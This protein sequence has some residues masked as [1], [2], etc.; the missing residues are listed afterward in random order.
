MRGLPLIAL[1][2]AA[3]LP[4]LAA[5]RIPLRPPLKGPLRLA[6]D[7]GE[8]RPHRLLPGIV[9]RT[10]GGKS[11]EPVSAAADGYVSRIVMRHDGYG[12][13]LYLRHPDGRSTVYAHLDRFSADLEA[14][15][16]RIRQAREA[17]EI[18]LVLDATL[19]PVKAGQRIGWTGSSGDVDGPSLHFEVREKGGL[20]ASDPFAA[21][22]RLADRT[23]PEITGLRIHALDDKLLPLFEITPQLRRG[24]AGYRVKGD[25]LLIGSWRAG[26]SISAQD[27]LPQG[28]RT[29]IRSIEIIA[30][31]EKV[32]RF[33][34]N[35][36]DPSMAR[37]TDAHLDYAEWVRSGRLFHR[38][39]LLPGNPLPHYPTIRKAGLLTLGSERSREVLV[40]VA[41]R[42]GN[43]R[44][45][46]FW[47]RRDPKA[48]EPEPRTF[49]YRIPYGESFTREE[50]G[51]RWTIPNGA[52][53]QTTFFR[54]ARLEDADGSPRFQLHEPG[55]PL[56]RF[57]QVALQ[58]PAG[59]RNADRL[60]A[61]YRSKEG[62]HRCGGNAAEGWL[63][64]RTRELGEYRL[65]V[66]T[67]A[68]EL[69][70]LAIPKRYGKGTRFRLM[71]ADDLLS[72]PW[73]RNLRW[74]VELNGCWLP[75]SWS[76]RD[77]E[78]SIDPASLVVRGENR[79]SVEVWDAGGNRS[80]WE[81]RFGF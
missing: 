76:P 26:V 70:P 78:L 23:A 62:W 69:R 38:C 48:P 7:F 66:D 50:P 3:C 40:T 43:K 71:M 74:R 14:Y 37:F 6:H 18:D 1:A 22:L 16:G 39:F 19:F 35:T 31:G 25:T 44:S 73:E 24:G 8:L 34:P 60:C 36:I 45:L 61:V 65:T 10:G 33:E 68:P 42:A 55:T 46:R 15:A 4:V 11:G 12:K 29:G 52:L 5:T 27:I 47:V 64:F 77:G 53:Y 72:T 56:Q 49:Q 63:E 20:V 67:I 58:L 30:D 28:G 17:E 81:H 79:L 80:S 2:L 41:D 54:F 13:A 9:L 51:I 75:G 32:F 59:G 21:G 57:M